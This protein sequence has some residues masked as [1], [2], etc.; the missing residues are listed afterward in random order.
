MK[1]LLFILGT[2]VLLGSCGSDT[3]TTET[4]EADAQTTDSLTIDESNEAMIYEPYVDEN[5]REYELGP[6]SDIAL[7]DQ[8][9]EDSILIM[10]DGTMAF[11]YPAPDTIWLD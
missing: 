5:G 11:V 2:I 4:S 7:S 1:K 8:Y 10:D 9:G 3:S 6:Q